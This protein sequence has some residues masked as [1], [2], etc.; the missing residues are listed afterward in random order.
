MADKRVV[1]TDDARNTGWLDGYRETGR[2]EPA[3][4]SQAKDYEKGYRRGA[5]DNCKDKD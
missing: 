3:D 1:V 2:R 5:K 4:A